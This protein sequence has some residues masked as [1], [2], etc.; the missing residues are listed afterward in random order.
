MK[1]IIVTT[2]IYDTP[3]MEKYAKIKDWEF[4]VVC[5]L[6]TPKLKVS[7]AEILT[8]EDQKKLPY[9]ICKGF[10]WNHV[11]RRNIGYIHALASGA[12]IIATIDNDN[13]PLKN[14]GFPLLGKTLSLKVVEGRDFFDIVRYVT[15]GIIWQRGTA[16]EDIN[17]KE[18]YTLKEKKIKIGIQAN[19]WLGEPDVD[20]ICR[21][22]RDM[23]AGK[24]MITKFNKPIGVGR[25]VFAPFDS[26]N[27]AF[28]RE[29]IAPALLPYDGY[30]DRMDDIWSSY[31]TER[32]LWETD[33]RV[34]FGAPTV[35][36]ERNPRTPARTWKEIEREVA[37][38]TILKQ[39][40]V[41][42]RKTTFK[43][44]NMTDNFIHL[45]EK[46]ERQDFVPKS[47]SSLWRKWAKDIEKYL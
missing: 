20:G 8:V 16:Y 15:N 43:N 23:E 45:S 26:Q 34:S 7:N 29:L 35:T 38:S 14:W 2:T 42:L 4:I 32:L 44:K 18:K 1:K 10:P 5:D 17:K 9:N 21:L 24:K 40:L 27:T 33:Y 41:F 11:Q 31:I 3:E 36:Q 37:F 47:Y 28:L 12:D 13:F 30:F 46:I 6:K 39:L 22:T 25:N 19:L